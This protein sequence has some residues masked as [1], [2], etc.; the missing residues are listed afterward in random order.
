M[1]AAPILLTLAAAAAGF[2]AGRTTAPAP[3]ASIPVEPESQAGAIVARFRGGTVTAVEFA[4]RVRSLAPDDQ[5]RFATPEGRRQFLD[6]VVRERLF[7]RAARERGYDR[8]PDL[9]LAA[10]RAVADQ[11]VEREFDLARIRAGLSDDE[12]RAW[13][14]SHLDEFQ[15][16][17][18]V[19]ASIVFLDAPDG[20]ARRPAKGAL[21]NAIAGGLAPAA[22]VDR[23][24]EAARRHSEDPISRPEGGRLPAMARAEFGRRFGEDLA[25]LVFAQ[26]DG[27]PVTRVLEGSRGVAVV[28][29]DGYDPGVRVPFDENRDAIRARAAVDERARR[30]DRFV[31]DLRRSHAVTVDE[32]ALGEVRV[33]VAPAR[34]GPSSLQGR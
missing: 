30:L 3:L 11:F 29:V 31:E 4:A 10:R 14:Q 16:P 19:R 7:A 17:E 13:Y 12:V 9:L 26:R 8:D 6:L 27:L 1:R 34:P 33:E 25:A 22:A 23:F 2:T 21:A 15:R 24:A 20:D 18:R 5:R 28:R 32:R